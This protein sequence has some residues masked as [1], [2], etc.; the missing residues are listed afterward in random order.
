M[1]LNV[2]IDLG[3]L[4]GEEMTVEEIITSEMRQQVLSEVAKIMAD[5]EVR[6]MAKEMSNSVRGEIERLMRERVD[7]FMGEEIALTGRWGEPAFVGTIEDLL[8]KTFDETVMAPVDAR[9]ERLSGCSSSSETYLEF[10]I[11]K[12]AE[13]FMK[14]DL[15]K[16]KES[17]ERVIR[18]EIKNQLEEYKAGVLKEEVSEAIKAILGK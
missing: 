11:K 17:V 15:Q 10:S 9:G 6:A 13:K 3:D 1:Q 2:T 8:K 14:T 4:Y 5:G 16:A 18:G 12:A 7:S